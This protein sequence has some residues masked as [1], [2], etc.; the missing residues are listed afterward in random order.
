MRRDATRCTDREP[1]QACGGAAV[2][3]FIA[4]SLGLLVLLVVAGC[5]AVQSR[6]LDRA[7]SQAMASDRSEWLDDGDLHV[8]LCGTGSPLPSRTRGGPCT[9]VLAG[10]HFIVIDAGRAS[11]LVFGLHRM[12]QQAIDAI[13]LTHFHSDHIAELGELGML[14]WALGRSEPLPV[15]GPPG[16]EEVVAGFERAYAQDS[17]YRTAHHGADLMPPENRPLV[18]R[19]VALPSQEGSATV[20]E[21]G[22]VKV[23]AFNVNHHPVSP[24]YGYRIDYGDRS[25]V[26]SGDTT[27]D[28]RVIRA[29]TGADVLVHEAL[30]KRM[31]GAGR[32][33]AESAGLERRQ[34][35][36]GD[37]IEY[38]TSPEEAAEVA[39]QADV[40]LLVLNHVVPPLDNAAAEY[41]FLSGVADVWDGEVLL[42]EDGIHIRLP[43]G[44]SQIEVETLE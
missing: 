30:S 17:A 26:V 40:G 23:T 1:I 6:I 10:G 37:I 11:G 36:L 38:H 8:F 31:I 29:A 42:G 19:P 35:I 44:S 22:E 9:A 7:A 5:D 41:L 20:F 12:P 28:P 15:Y 18:A 2:W 32:D 27:M 13:L 33:A 24:A 39:K 25:V 34:R 16:V 4:T 43:R 14:S 3:R 21:E